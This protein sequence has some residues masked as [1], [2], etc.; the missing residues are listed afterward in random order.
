[1]LQILNQRLTIKY[2][3]KKDMHA[4]LVGII[5]LLYFVAVNPGLGVSI[6]H[7]LR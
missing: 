3:K 2:E 5:G 1:M 4:L 7:I 6:N